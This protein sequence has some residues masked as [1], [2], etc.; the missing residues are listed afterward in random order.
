MYQIHAIPDLESVVIARRPASVEVTPETAGSTD[1]EAAPD[2][3]A[4]T[5]R[6][7]GSAFIKVYQ[8]CSPAL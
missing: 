6:R 2:T 8:K 3:A 4:D 1:V 7:T 5:Y